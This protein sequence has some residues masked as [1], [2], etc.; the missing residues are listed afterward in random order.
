V[1]DY[2]LWQESNFNVTERYLTF[3]GKVYAEDANYIAKIKQ[4]A[5]SN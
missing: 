1:A 3:L 4:M 2:K 5:G